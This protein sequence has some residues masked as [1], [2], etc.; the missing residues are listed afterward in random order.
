[1]GTALKRLAGVLLTLMR[2]PRRALA[3][4][5]VSLLAALTTAVPAQAVGQQTLIKRLAAYSARLGPASGQYVVDIT[6]GL[7]LFTHRAGTALAPAS[8]EKL[9]TT[10]TALMAFGPSATL[11]TTVR[12]AATARLDTAGVLHGD[13]YLVGG[14][15][16][17]LNDIALRSLV[18]Q[19]RRTTGV[20][21]FTGSVVGDESVFDSKRGSAASGFVTDPDLG[22]SLGGLTWAHGRARPGGPAAVAAARLQA[23]L[24]ASGIKGG[25]KARAG[26]VALAPGGPGS[27][28]ARVS[29]PPMS[30]LIAITNQPSDN[31]YA[32]TLLKD[33]GVRF[34]GAGT[35]AAGLGVVR[36]QLSGIGIAPTLTDGS[37]LSRADRTT[38]F[39]V[40]SLL[41]SMAAGRYWPV[42]EASLATAGRSGTLATRM[43]GTS[44]SSRCHAKTG[45]LRDV[46]ALSGY[47]HSAG[48]H[49]MAFSFLENA[50]SPVA[51]K[52]IEDKMASAIASYVP[53]PSAK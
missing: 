1:M 27:V 22:G 47:C 21:R 16:P 30:S 19:L 4:L 23:L 38:P 20:R 50:V 9:F 24:K 37:G 41:R 33:L 39:Q 7:A 40:V 46:S 14:G 12:Q 31:F 51:A 18:T 45:T 48:G 52:R 29:S 15:D 36:K 49:L 35:T 25:R 43:R 44:A 5:A 8:N 42:F 26:R 17:S 28:L 32:E 10:S 2:M 3:G 34:G 11:E 13:L 6:A 53:P